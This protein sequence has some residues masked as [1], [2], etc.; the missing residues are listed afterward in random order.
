MR[1]ADCAVYGYTHGT[2]WLYIG[3]KT[4]V[5]CSLTSEFTKAVPEPIRSAEAETSVKLCRRRTDWSRGA[6]Y[7]YLELRNDVYGSLNDAVWCL[8]L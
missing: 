7:T 2:A 8:V 4:Q 5:R 6:V 3:H 1:A